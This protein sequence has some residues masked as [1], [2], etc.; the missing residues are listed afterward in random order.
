MVRQGGVVCV[1]D[2]QPPCSELLLFRRLSQVIPEVPV[3][4][5]QDLITHQAEE[6]AE[7]ANCREKDETDAATL[8]RLIV[9]SLNHKN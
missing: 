6:V 4:V 3:I 1:V 8:E 7:V 2:L 9:T 5:S